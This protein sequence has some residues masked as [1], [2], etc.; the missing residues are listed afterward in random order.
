MRLGSSPPAKSSVT[1]LN[2]TS[3][4]GWITNVLVRGTKMSPV[5]KYGLLACVHVV[6][7]PTC[8]EPLGTIVNP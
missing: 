2:R 1:G 5:S 3:T 4:P 6:I 8:S 7:D